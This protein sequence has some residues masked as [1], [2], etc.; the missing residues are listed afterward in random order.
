MDEKKVFLVV[1]A[2]PEQRKQILD[3]ICKHVTD[4]TLFEAADGV[5]GLSKLKN[6]P[7]HVLICATELPKLPGLKL[8]DQGLEARGAEHTAFILCGVPPEEERHLDE[9]VTGRVQYWQRADDEKEFMQVLSRAM[10]Y[11]SHSEKA[12]FYLRFLTPGDVLLREGDAADFVYFVRKGQLRASKVRG[13][14]DVTLGLI[15]VGEFVGEMAYINGEPRS[16]QVSAVS[17]C[18]LIE[19]PVG[20]FERVLFRR[21]AWSKALMRTL[22]KRVKQ[23][24]EKKVSDS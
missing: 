2:E 10:N 1:A 6:V 19:V 4:P 20:T 3:L 12:D 21:P 17:E 15:E 24:N 18:E 22:S 5:M 16:A 13:D 9:I 23:A 14:K 8:V 7:P 11:S